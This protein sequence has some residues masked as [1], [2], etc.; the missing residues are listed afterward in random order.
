MTIIIRIGYNRHLTSTPPACLSQTYQPVP[1]AT[2]ESI[3]TLLK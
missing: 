1:S 3:E 2:I